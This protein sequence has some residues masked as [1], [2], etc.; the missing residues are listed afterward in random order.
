MVLAIER[1]DA[2]H[3]QHVRLAMRS[4]LAPAYYRH[5]HYVWHRPGTSNCIKIRNAV[6]GCTQT[7][8]VIPKHA[9]CRYAALP[10]TVCG[11]K[12]AYTLVLAEFSE[13]ACLD[14]LQMNC[15]SYSSSS[16][17][18]FALPFVRLMFNCTTSSETSEPCGAV[19]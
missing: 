4:R 2:G 9:S 6:H 18:S 17:R 19:E 11:C 15:K 5:L 16:V 7:L 13:Q 1:F 10:C 12:R 3:S 14:A 8:F